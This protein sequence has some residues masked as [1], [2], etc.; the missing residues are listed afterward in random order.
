MGDGDADLVSDDRPTSGSSIGS[1]DYASVVDAADDR[2]AGAGGFGER[3]ASR[4]E[5]RIAVVVGEVEAGHDG[6]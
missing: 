4:V 6:G 3:N 2:G 1:D 5:S